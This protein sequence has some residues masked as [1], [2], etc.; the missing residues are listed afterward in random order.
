M[1]PSPSSSRSQKFAD[2]SE[3]HLK[4]SRSQIQP[5]SNDAISKGRSAT[6]PSQCTSNQ[7]TVAAAKQCPQDILKRLQTLN[8][9]LS[10]AHQPLP[11]QKGHFLPTHACDS[12]CRKLRIIGLGSCGTV[13]EP[14]ETSPSALAIERAGPNTELPE[15][16]MRNDFDL[17][18]RVRDALISLHCRLQSAFADAEILTTPQAHCF[19]LGDDTD[20]W[21]S[22]ETCDF[23]TFPDSHTGRYPAFTL[24]RIPPVPQL[25]GMRLWTNFLEPGR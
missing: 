19:W 17:T 11:P 8:P 25:F 20:F 7:S 6:L 4:M 10:A 3:E 5:G 18:N 16:S 14:A 1:D 22:E 24:D 15:A 13:F 9:P 23:G 12:P 2:M 21:Q